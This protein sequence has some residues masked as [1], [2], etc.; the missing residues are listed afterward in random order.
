[1]TIRILPALVLVWWVAGCTWVE[2]APEAK[3]VAL[4]GSEAEAQG[5]ERVGQTIVSLR[6]RV[7]GIERSPEKV[8][9]E[10]RTLARNS[11]AKDLKG[12]AILPIS[13]V[14]EGRQTFAV[15]RCAN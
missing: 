14:S 13:E 3:D 5:C 9:E 15:Y 11:A 2:L 4:L 10:L 6:D 8:R 7:A 1:M 12:N